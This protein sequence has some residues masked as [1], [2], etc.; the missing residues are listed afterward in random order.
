MLNSVHVCTS[1]FLLIVTIIK[2]G[3]KSIDQ[4]NSQL[5]INFKQ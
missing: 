3:L 4:P 2:M 1:A 5:L